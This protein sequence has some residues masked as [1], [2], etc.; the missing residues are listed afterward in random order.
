MRLSNLKSALSAWLVLGA[1]STGAIAQT[2]VDPDTIDQAYA[3]SLAGSGNLIV[4]SSTIKAA[5]DA[6][7]PGDV[8]FVPPGTYT[9][10][11][12]VRTSGLTIVG[13]R[14]AVLDGTGTCQRH[15]N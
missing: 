10:N 12:Q 6:A 5:V 13:P 4:V 14:T 8:I 7:S 2:A 9:E 1:S 3:Q 15:R 11:V